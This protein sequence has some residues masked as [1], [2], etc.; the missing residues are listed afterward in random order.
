MVSIATGTTQPLRESPAIASVV[1]AADIAAIG[2]TELNEVLETIPGL[3][4]GVSGV[5]YKPIFSIRGIH[6][7]TNPQVLV[8]INGLPIKNVFDGSRGASWGRMP[9][10]GIARIEVIRGP[11]S[12]LY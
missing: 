6:T 8:L 4:V 5:G 7:Q 9:V 11:G 2:A 1:T 10:T 3:H 12:A